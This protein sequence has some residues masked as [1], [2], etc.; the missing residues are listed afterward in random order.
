MNFP[1][2]FQVEYIENCHIYYT[3]SG[4]TYDSLNIFVSMFGRKKQKTRWVIYS[5]ANAS[6]HVNPEIFIRFGE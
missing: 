6:E 1:S 5:Y 4:H 3:Q 2:P